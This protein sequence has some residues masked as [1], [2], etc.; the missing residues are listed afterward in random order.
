MNLLD[1]V[2]RDNADD[3]G[4]CFIRFSNHLA[5]GLLIDERPDRIVHSHKI[6]VRGNPG[7][8][9]LN[10]LLPAV[11]T[12]HKVNGLSRTFRFQ[13]LPYPLEILLAQRHK[14]LTN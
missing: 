8:R 12:L 9:V 1:R 13:V 7:Q 4:S 3:G 14:D 11:A 5:Q 10:G 2:D 6:R